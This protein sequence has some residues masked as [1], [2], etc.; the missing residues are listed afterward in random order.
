MGIDLV[1]DDVERNLLKEREV[2]Q[3]AENLLGQILKDTCEQIRKLKAT[4]Y[5]IDHDLENKESNLRIDRRNVTLK[6]T[7]FN[8]KIY[9]DIS[10]LDKSCVTLPS[11]VYNLHTLPSEYNLKHL[12]SNRSHI[13]L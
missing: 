7:D 10:R 4:L 9:H 6:E 5:Y 1:H 12:T 11:I 2:I 3:G 13:T 8:L